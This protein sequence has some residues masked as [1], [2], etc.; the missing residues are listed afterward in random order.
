M[1]SN[2]PPLINPLPSGYG[3]KADDHLLEQYKLYVDS[4]QSLSDRRLSTNN[5]LLTINSSL[6]TLVGLLASLL[7][8]RKPLIM[9][10]AAGF[11]LSLAWSLLLTSFKRLNAAKF[12]VIHEVEHHLPANLFQEEWRR[13]NSG[14]RRLYT[15]MSD[16]ERVIPFLFLLFYLVLGVFI[17]N[18]PA[19]VEDKV[20]KIQIQS[21]V[22]VE[23]NNS[24]VPPSK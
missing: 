21:P 22:Q 19:P 24:S 7:G 8:D 15:P 23:V 12:E 3:S 6:L 1:P 14:G 4:S 2:P 18:W 13:L 5:Y 17:W 20:Q 10:A 11:L 9:I 16:L